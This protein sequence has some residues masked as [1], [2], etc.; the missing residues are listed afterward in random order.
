[1][2]TSLNELQQGL[3]FR[4]IKAGSIEETRASSLKGIIK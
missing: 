4:G 1:M 2:N 3:G